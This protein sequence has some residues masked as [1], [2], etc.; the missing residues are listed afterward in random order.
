MLLRLVLDG[1]PLRFP[2]FLCSSIVYFTTLGPRIIL[3]AALRLAELF[4]H[5]W[6][7]CSLSLRQWFATELTEVEKV[8]GKLIFMT[9]WTLRGALRFSEW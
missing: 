8:I 1:L 9:V 4:Q 7:H 2:A 3:L 5:L 6:F